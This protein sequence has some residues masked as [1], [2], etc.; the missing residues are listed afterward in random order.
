VMR[1]HGV[2]FNDFA[3]MGRANRWHAVKQPET[4]LVATE[5]LA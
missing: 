5:A 3:S 4:E 2:R 1:A